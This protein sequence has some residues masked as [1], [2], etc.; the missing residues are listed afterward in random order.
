M[1]DSTSSSNSPSVMAPDPTPRGL[2]PIPVAL[3]VTTASDL[4]GALSAVPA[5]AVVM[6]VSGDLDTG[7]IDA[8]D[9]AAPCPVDIAGGAW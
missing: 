2:H 4:V 6:S 1:A 8:V 3:G 5:G 7:L 9:M